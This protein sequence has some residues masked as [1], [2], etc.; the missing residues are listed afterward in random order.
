MPQSTAG[1]P[2]SASTSTSTGGR[3]RGDVAVA[4]KGLLP[5]ASSEPDQPG[6]H[7]AH[8]AALRRL[9]LAVRGVSPS[10]GSHELRLRPNQA[11][12]LRRMREELAQRQ[13]D[14][15]PPVRL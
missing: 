7:E 4:A 3:G 5:G 13:T 15:E 6:I 11:V 2:T 1:A 12:S 9:R 8:E 10:P 14:T